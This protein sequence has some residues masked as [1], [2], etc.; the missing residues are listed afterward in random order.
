MSDAPETT[1]NVTSGTP[2]VTIE[3]IARYQPQRRN[4]NKHT[5]RGLGM[6]ETAMQ[7]DGFVAPMTAANDGEVIDGSARLEKAA[8]V[9]GDEVLVIEHDGTRPIIMKRTDIPNASTPEAKRISVAANRI[10]AVDL[11]FDAEMLAEIEE[12]TPGLLAGLFT[13]GEMESV[14]GKKPE[15]ED[16]GGKIDK[17]A[18]LQKK[19][20]TSLGQLWVIKSNSG[21][22][23][24]RLVCGDCTDAATVA[25]LM[26]DDKAEMV[27][28]DPPYGVAIGDKN[29]F[30][31]SIAPSN[32][33]EENLENDTL[34]E[35]ALV[36]MLE[37]SFD[38][39]IAHCTGGAATCSIRPSSKGSGNMAADDPMG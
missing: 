21:P 20:G 23:E 34:D 26:G 36:D 37:K 18:E 28:T 29:V 32:R 30:L 19:W 15:G 6:L 11:D 24:H 13:P 5:P 39:A 2:K 17:A 8:T 35:P 3:P 4:A 27:W 25:R 7:T 16:P 10:A 22:G 9:F 14:F 1:E 38:N 33:V 31:N 12:Q